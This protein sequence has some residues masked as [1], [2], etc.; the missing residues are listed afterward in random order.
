MSFDKKHGDFIFNVQ[1]H[2]VTC[3]LIGPFNE[4]GMLTWI[5]E[6]KRVV[7]RALLLKSGNYLSSR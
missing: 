6:I 2:L 4:E 7:N 3:E 1:E 5:T